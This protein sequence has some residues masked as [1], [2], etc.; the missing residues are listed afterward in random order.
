MSD[1]G[2]EKAQEIWKAYP[3]LEYGDGWDDARI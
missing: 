2:R 1:V 3:I